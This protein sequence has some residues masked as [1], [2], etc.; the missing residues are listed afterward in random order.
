[1]W[2]C[3][4]RTRDRKR[5]D[6]DKAKTGRSAKIMWTAVPSGRSPRRKSRRAGLYTCASPV[7]ARRLQRVFFSGKMGLDRNGFHDPLAIILRDLGRINS[8]A[9][10]RRAYG[11]RVAASQV[12]VQMMERFVYGMPRRERQRQA[13]PLESYT[14]SSI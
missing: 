14:I 4:P 10:E 9:G 5:F 8:T 6:R 7:G 11:Y 12:Q 2:K 13:L 1:V 3:R